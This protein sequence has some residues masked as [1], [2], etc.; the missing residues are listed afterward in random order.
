M[1][2][3]EVWAHIM[4]QVIMPSANQ[5]TDVTKTTQLDLIAI[6]SLTAIQSI[7]PHLLL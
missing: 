6:A 5:T 2:F 4:A 1:I 7:N 3:Y